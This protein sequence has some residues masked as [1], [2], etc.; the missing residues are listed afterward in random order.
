[1]NSQ[2][3]LDI[4]YYRMHKDSKVTFADG[5]SFQLLDHDPAVLRFFMG[6]AHLI[7]LLI[8]RKVTCQ[9]YAMEREGG[10]EREKKR[11]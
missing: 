10:R 7:F 5:R 11:L 6:V 1:M 3:Q 8:G 2:S 4:G 9:N